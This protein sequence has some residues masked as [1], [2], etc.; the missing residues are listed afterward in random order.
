MQTAITTLT[1]EETAR[2]LGWSPL[3]FQR[4]YK[5]MVREQGFPLRMPGGNF[6]APAI[7]RWMAQASGMIQPPAPTPI[8]AQR[9]NL[10]LIYGGRA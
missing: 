8:D 7:D 3:T 4:K 1:L 10:K 6:Y 9:N 5:N 2:L